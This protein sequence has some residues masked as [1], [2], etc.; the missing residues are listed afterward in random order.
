MVYYNIVES[1]V[2]LTSDCD[3]AKNFMKLLEIVQDGIHS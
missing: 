3:D 1:H 2:I